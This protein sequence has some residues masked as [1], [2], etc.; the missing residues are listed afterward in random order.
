MTM[1]SVGIAAGRM[2][3]EVKRQFTERP[4]LLDP[5]SGA[6]PDYA[7][8][9]AISTKASLREMIL[10]GLLVILS[11]IVTGV[12]FGVE[13]V[14]GLLSGS[15]VSSV[16][17][18]ISQSNT[19]GAWDNAKKYVWCPRTFTHSYNTNCVSLTHGISLECYE[20]QVH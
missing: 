8:C 3:E 11:P 5:L 12:F 19:G 20:T 14:C 1:K 15:L 10:P 4:Q 16:Q 7:T 18:A 13:A 6:K 2:V 9:I 17:M